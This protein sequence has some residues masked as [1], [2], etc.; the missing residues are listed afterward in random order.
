MDVET[1]DQYQHHNHMSCGCNTNKKGYSTSSSETKVKKPIFIVKK[2]NS[3]DES[4]TSKC[5]KTVWGDDFLMSF[6]WGDEKNFETGC[7]ISHYIQPELIGWNPADT[8]VRTVCPCNP[9]YTWERKDGHLVVRNE[10]IEGDED[11]LFESGGQVVMKLS[12]Q[13]PSSAIGEG[14]S[15]YSLTGLGEAIGKYIDNDTIVLDPSN[16]NKMTAVFDYNFYADYNSNEK[17]FEENPDVNK[18]YYND[19]ALDNKIRVKTDGF[20]IIGDGVNT[21]LTATNGD[22][23]ANDTAHKFFLNRAL[24]NSREVIINSLEHIEEVGL[25]TATA[26]YEAPKNYKWIIEIKS[27]C[28]ISSNTIGKFSISL[29]V[30]VNGENKTINQIPE[31][32]IKSIYN[33]SGEYK[34]TLNF[35]S[36]FE[37]TGGIAQFSNKVAVKSES[38]NNQP[39]TLTNNTLT[40]EF[41]LIK[42]N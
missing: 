24:D 36:I 21:P 32:E 18:A 17:I 12:S 3:S 26:P 19:G 35:T 11:E 37:Y 42:S 38:D 28:S 40:G 8:L 31:E 7:S 4:I 33:P 29:S 5:N 25:G 16:G 14:Y 23:Y 6:L 10:T 9:D 39:F 34:G 30:N 15:A 2:S 20:S 22:I 27:H 13:I 41:K 1:Q